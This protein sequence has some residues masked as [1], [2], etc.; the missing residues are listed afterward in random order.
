MSLQ[1][2]GARGM[3]DYL[4][5]LDR[6]VTVVTAAR[7]RLLGAG[8]PGGFLW[9]GTDIS[10]AGQIDA[11]RSA[12]RQS[13]SRR[14]GNQ[15]AA[16]PLTIRS[17]R[18]TSAFVAHQSP[19]S[20]FATRPRRRLPAPLPAVERVDPLGDGDPLVTPLA[21][22]RAK[23][24]SPC[25]LLLAS[26]ARTPRSATLVSGPQ[27]GDD[28]ETAAL[29]LLNVNSEWIWAGHD[30]TTFGGDR[31]VEYIPSRLAAPRRQLR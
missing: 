29:T 15:Q 3:S 17:T 18:K 24:Q 6:A 2:R 11:M 16:E 27:L 20:I 13:A 25:N 12:S 26:D 19:L 23:V 22:P 28:V 31:R 8:H 7:E 10:A 9:A 21:P 5:T 30:G 4:K 1:T 14:A